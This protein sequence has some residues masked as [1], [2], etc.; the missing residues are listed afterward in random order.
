MPLIS[1][2][3]STK[4]NQMIFDDIKSNKLPSSPTNQIVSDKAKATKTH[5]WPLLFIPFTFCTTNA[6]NPFHVS[7]KRSWKCFKKPKTNTNLKKAIKEKL[8]NSITF[9]QTQT[10]RQTNY[11]KLHASQNALKHFSPKTSYFYCMHIPFTWSALNLCSNI[12]CLT[13]HYNK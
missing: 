1:S 13:I 12:Q 3:P 7:K 9:C 10:F 8:Y 11:S 4:T 6:I 5:K 2:I